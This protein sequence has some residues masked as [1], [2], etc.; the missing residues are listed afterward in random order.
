MKEEDVQNL[1]N[2]ALQCT[3]SSLVPLNQEQLD[4]LQMFFGLNVV[5]NG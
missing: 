2:M 5:G 1:I 4:A 3:V